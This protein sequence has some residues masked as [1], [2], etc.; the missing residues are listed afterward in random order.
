MMG[1]ISGIRRTKYEEKMVLK[2]ITIF[3][4]KVPNLGTFFTSKKLVNEK[5]RHVGETFRFR[6][7]KNRD[8]DGHRFP[9]GRAPLP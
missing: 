7:R 3:A 4:V 8:H 6:Q 9:V 1:L 5:S 2:L